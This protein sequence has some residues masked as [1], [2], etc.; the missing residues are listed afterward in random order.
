MLLIS[1]YHIVSDFSDSGRTY[2]LAKSE[3]STKTD[4]SSVL[5]GRYANPKG[6]ILKRDWLRF[7]TFCRLCLLQLISNDRRSIT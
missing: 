5:T 2:S 1:C 6:E 4:S 3:V 7:I